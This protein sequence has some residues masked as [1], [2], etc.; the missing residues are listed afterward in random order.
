MKRLR[1]TFHGVGRIGLGVVLA[2]SAMLTSAAIAYATEAQGSCPE[3][4]AS[5][6]PKNGFRPSGAYNLAG[7]MGQGSGA[8]EL[9]FEHPCVTSTKYP[10][11]I[12]IMFTYYGGEMAELLKMQGEAADQQT[13]QNATSE[14]ARSKRPVKTEALAGGRIVYVDYMSECPAE[15][16]AGRGTANR[17]PIPNIKLNGLFRTA[18]ARLEVTLEGRISTELAKAAVAEV[19]GNFGKAQFGKSN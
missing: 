6:L 10:A 9:P 16:A 7:S 3:I 18:N 19:Y 14:L 17:P 4:I 11:R 8:A 13:I 15:G 1:S 2:S 12:T 5:L